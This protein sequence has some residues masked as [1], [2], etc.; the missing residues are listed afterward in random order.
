MSIKVK[1]LSWAGN[2]ANTAMCRYHV[3]HT[4][5]GKFKAESPTFGWYP[6]TE[7]NN[8][9]AA[10]QACQKHWAKQVIDLLE[11]ADEL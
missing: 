9:K 1:R 5:E 4:S 10:V 11:V 3:E 6:D 2:Y 8:K 7:Y